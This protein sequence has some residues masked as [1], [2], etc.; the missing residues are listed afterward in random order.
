MR[1]VGSGMWVVGSV[2][3]R[4]KALFLAPGTACRRVYG[5]A[6][7]VKS[8]MPPLR[9]GRCVRGAR[10]IDRRLVWLLAGAALLLAAC[11]GN[12][13][14]GR[15]RPA[16]GG[17]SVPSASA[18]TPV[19]STPAGANLATPASTGSPSS[20]LQGELDA[21]LLQPSDLPPGYVAK[22][23]TS[24]GGAISGETASAATVYSAAVGPSSSA[25][26]EQVFV[27]LIGFKDAQSARDALDQSQQAV[28]EVTNLPGSTITVAPLSVGPTL[29]DGA[30]SFSIGG[31]LAGLDI[32]GYAIYWL[33][34]RVLAGVTQFTTGSAISIDETAAL[35]RKQDA[36]L[37]GVQ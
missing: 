3:G 30:M 24:F 35:A 7:P 4:L 37:A 34:G 25:G 18:V 26:L 17:T 11:S 29:G 23:L 10:V 22:H 33:H 1:G 27:A 15:V 12:N 14:A 31:K 6:V 2:V 13:N 36:K 16:A 20:G 9:C 8:A 5:W 32:S 19:A 21:A 28:E